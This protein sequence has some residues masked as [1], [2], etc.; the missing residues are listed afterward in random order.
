MLAP[1][2]LLEFGGWGLSDVCSG[3]ELSPERRCGFQHGCS[4]VKYEVRASRNTHAHA[5]TMGWLILSTKEKGG[6]FPR[7]R[8]EVMSEAGLQE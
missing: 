7:G 6:W 2:Y 5:R 1:Y 4:V 8:E 3:M